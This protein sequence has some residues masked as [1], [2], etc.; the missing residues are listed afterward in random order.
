MKV[1]CLLLTVFFCCLVKEHRANG[2]SVIV[3]ED[4]LI[5]NIPSHF[6][7]HGWE[8][9]TALGFIHQNMGDPIISQLLSNLGGGAVRFGVPSSPPSSLIYLPIDSSILSP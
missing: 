5:F 9:F 7:S 4:E 1:L 8:P 3:N 6:C 2:A